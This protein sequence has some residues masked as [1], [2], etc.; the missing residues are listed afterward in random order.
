[1]ES[2]N[3]PTTTAINHN[4]RRFLI[5]HA[6]SPPVVHNA[7]PTSTK[8]IPITHPDGIGGD[9]YMLL[10]IMYIPTLV[11]TNAT[12]KQTTTMGLII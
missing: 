9:E 6:T 1:M 8:S 7:N 5:N 4:A 3:V 10:T 2:R 12:S 11:D